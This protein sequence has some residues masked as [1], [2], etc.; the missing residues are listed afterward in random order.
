MGTTKASR[1]HALEV[2]LLGGFAVRAGGREVPAS[3]FERRKARSLLKLL[4]LQ[5]DGRI[6][7]DRALELLWPDLEARA[8]ASQ[9]YKA[10]HQVRQALAGARAG[11]ELRDELLVLGAPE[12]VAVDVERFEALAE[13]ALR[14]RDPE[15]LARAAEA[16]GGDLL[17][18]DLYEAWT[19]EPRERIAERHAAVLVALGEAHL[20]RD[21]IEDAAD[22][23]RQAA[24][25]DPLDER[26]QR[27]LMLAYARLG[28]RERALQKYRALKDAL[29]SEL[30]ATPSAESARLAAAIERGEVAPARPQAP[31]PQEAASLP[32]L[33]GRAQQLTAIVER[34][35]DLSARRGGALGVEGPAGIGKTRLLREAAALAR[36][37]GF[38][39]ASGRAREEEGPLPY[40]PFVEAVSAALAKDRANAELLP[41]PFAELIPA[42]PPGAAVPK[43]D[44]LTARTLLFS[45]LE[46][47]FAARAKKAPL[48]LVLDDLHAADTASL[49]LF[50]Y[51]A[52]R[53][54]E[55][56]LL[57]LAA[58]RPDEP[59]AEGALAST[60]HSLQRDE[61]LATLRL[62]PLSHAEAS[63]L[64]ARALGGDAD[65]ELQEQLFRWSEGNPLFARELVRQLQ[66][67]KRIVRRGGLWR[68]PAGDAPLPPSLRELLRRRWDRLR[69]AAQRLVQAAALIG[70]DV[71]V[72]ELRAAAGA[73]P[74]FLDLLE[75]A[76][77]AG[78]LTEASTSV[79]F[80]HA[81]YRDAVAQ[82]ISPARARELHGRIAE[83]LEKLQGAVEAIAHHWARAG[84]PARAVHYLLRAGDRAEQ[85][86]AHGE[87]L[88]RFSEALA[89]A[90]ES[91]PEL[92]AHAH[93]RIGDVHRAT[94]DV[95]RAL[96]AYRAALDSAPRGDLHRKIALAAV[97]A[98]DMPTAAEHLRKAEAGAEGLA[99]ARV[100][101]AAA[102]FDWHRNELL[103][104]VEKAQQ[105]LAIAD[106]KGAA[107]EAQQACEMLALSYLPLGR[108]EEGL[109]YELRRTAAGWSPEVVVATDGHLCLWEYH[110]HG[111]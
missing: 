19:Q 65:G 28:D 49:E 3:A 97:L 55:L 66:G 29:A 87:A 70:R 40:G 61:R 83:A 33:V 56:P 63:E 18:E 90:P 84:D 76:A 78:V 100:L 43:S 109:K 20:Q 39:V 67:E 92:R 24:A 41:A 5:K 68:A 26:A 57:I 71:P 72:A 95:A 89:L 77:A 16:C 80:P 22:A 37:R 47:F 93:E 58:W 59:G 73:E 74:E 54:A 30:Q 42:L 36:A 2:S 50:H 52:R 94:G 15:S 27:G 98:L 106:E 12:G 34:L 44:P 105:A 23:F 46:R 1:A 35:D 99:R 13:E 4:A 88:A 8:A 101:I 38:H 14:S 32:P 86:F 10:M 62:P 31:A 48:V 69:P 11:I 53:A 107:V 108:W 75:E 103:S 110:V 6:H 25:R 45:G 7:R 91:A 51:L 79:R 17:P 104:A 82:Q 9:L 21:R 102:L 85:V 81:L 111:E 60:L 96:A 64:A